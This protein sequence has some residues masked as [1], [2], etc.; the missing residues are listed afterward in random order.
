[1]RI[2][3]AEM[4]VQRAPFENTIT[5]LMFVIRECMANATTYKHQKGHFLNFVLEKEKKSYFLF[6]HDGQPFKNLEEIMKEGLTPN[7]SGEKGWSF[8]GCGLT[9][10]MSY[11]NGMNPRLT[12]CSHTK[13][14][15][16]KSAT[17]KPNWNTNQWEIEETP[18]WG[19]KLF[20]TL[21]RRLFEEYQVF[22]IFRVPH[23]DS[24]NYDGDNE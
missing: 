22:Y 23:E 14:D 11:M 10:C 21:G 17:S 24:D 18:E 6:M 9:Y 2:I 15:G 19:N 7:E 13:E 5:N 12:I 3:P 1:M 16:F 20:G 8:Q 4:N